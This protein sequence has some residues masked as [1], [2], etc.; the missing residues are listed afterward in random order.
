MGLELM[1]IGAFARRAGVAT[2][3]LRFY[4]E[5]R[6]LVASRTSGGQRR[7][8]RS[9]L[10]RVAFIR[11]AQRVGVTLEEV[12]QALSSLP[13]GRTPGPRDWERL[14][15]R[16]APMLAARIAQLQALQRTLGHCIGCGC[17]SLARCGLVNADDHLGEGGP[18]AR[19]WPFP[20]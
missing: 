8:R 19:R 17:L 6:L 9:D 5:K 16:W 3:A 14:A 15:S 7:Y 1:T 20:A 2:S 12:G 4:E 11:A 10:R 18:G 13:S